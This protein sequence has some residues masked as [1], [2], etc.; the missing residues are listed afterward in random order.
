MQKGLNSKPVCNKKYLHSKT[1]Y[2]DNNI[3]IDFHRDKEPKEGSL[4]ICWSV[5]VIDSVYSVY[6]K[7]KNN[8]PKVFFVE[9]NRVQINSSHLTICE[10]ASKM[11]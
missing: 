6:K 3:N 8:Y 9:C 4:C 7:N 5:I 2:Y 1:K 10:T 11:S